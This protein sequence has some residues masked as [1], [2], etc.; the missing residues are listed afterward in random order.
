MRRIE[1]DSAVREYVKW[2][3]LSLAVVES[4]SSKKPHTI[5]KIFILLNEIDGRF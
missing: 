2:T 4:K 3:E 5:N 1:A